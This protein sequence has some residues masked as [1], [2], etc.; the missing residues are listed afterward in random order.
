MT[1]S[2]PLESETTSIDILIGNDYYFDT[3]L[4]HKIE[5]QPGLYLLGSKLRCFL[6]GRTSDTEID[7]EESSLLIFTYGGT[8]I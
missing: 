5:V 6:T 1:D 8:E 7:D 4:S 3:E 2:L